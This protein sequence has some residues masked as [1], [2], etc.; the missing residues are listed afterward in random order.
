MDEQVPLLPPQ[1]QGDGFTKIRLSS[2]HLER[3]KK[4]AEDSVASIQI[5]EC[6]SMNLDEQEEENR[7]LDEG[8]QTTTESFRSDDMIEKSVVEEVEESVEKNE[9][10]EEETEEKES[11]VENHV[12]ETVET[13]KNGDCGSEQMEDNAQ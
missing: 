5:A 8:F 13:E 7:R 9:T 1:P 10:V 6:H 4:A 2:E 3:E 12:G 11:V